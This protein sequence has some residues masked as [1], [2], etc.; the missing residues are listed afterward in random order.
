MAKIDLTHILDTRPTIQ[1]DAVVWDSLFNDSPIPQLARFAKHF[2]QGGNTSKTSHD[3]KANSVHLFTT[4]LPSANDRSS[5]FLE[6]R[7]PSQVEI[8]FFV[9]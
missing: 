9:S 7:T 8:G 6:R 2:A 4:S 5:D 3:T 1:L